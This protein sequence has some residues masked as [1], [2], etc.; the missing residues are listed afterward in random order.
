MIKLFIFLMVLIS[1]SHAKSLV[2]GVVPQQ[3]PQKM[4]K[5][6]SPI[7]KY[8]S[9]ETGLQITFKTENSIPKFEK[10][11]YAGK[12]DIA[13]S[14]PYHY[15]LAHEKTGH[16]AVVRFDKMIVGIL[17]AKKQSEIN[18]L[19]DVI[20]KQFLFPAPMAFAATIL[21][22]Y[23]VLNKKN[24]S[25]EQ[26]RKFKYV[27]SHDSVYLGVQRGIGD[28]GGGIVRT[29]NKF[30]EKENL[31]I[32]YKTD[33][34]PSHPISISSSLDKKDFEKIKTALLKMPKKLSQ[35]VNPK[36]L[37][38]TSDAEYDVVKQLAVRLNIF[39]NR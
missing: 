3:S 5:T 19:D 10:E 37:K 2:F 20:D 25:I 33:K 24:Y 18:S 17:V 36:P 11:L 8:L 27:N 22:K 15:I 6:W 39:E 35:A 38:Q 21:T 12:Y 4:Y 30:K 13:Y 1:F 31:K 28:I 9:K 29:F 16:D 23:E 7:V 32:I 34:Y 26:S 14:S